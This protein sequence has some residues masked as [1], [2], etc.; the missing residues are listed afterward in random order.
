MTLMA[1]HTRWVVT[2]FFPI[3]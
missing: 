3:F 2:I 1:N